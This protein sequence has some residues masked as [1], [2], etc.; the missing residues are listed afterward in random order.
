MRHR[1]SPS[2]GV[3]SSAA[4]V[5][6]TCAIAVSWHQ[7]PGRDGRYAEPCSA[8][9]IT[10]RSVTDYGVPN[11]QA[12]YDGIDY[13]RICGDF[14]R[15]LAPWAAPLARPDQHLQM[16]R[17][18]SVLARARVPRAAPIVRP[19]ELVEAASARGLLAQ[20]LLH[21]IHRT[22]RNTS[23]MM[24]LNARPLA[25]ASA[26]A[27]NVTPLNADLRE[28]RANIDRRAGRRAPSFHGVRDFAAKMRKRLVGH[29]KPAQ[30]T[31]AGAVGGSGHAER[32]T[33][34]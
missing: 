13:T 34:W 29:R 6:G 27:H 11:E 9:I 1:R 23:A 25:S 16:P 7:P 26:F 14:A 15:A 12:N 21:K 8:S 33:T 28:I 20:D 10:R 18:R 19:L 3:S 30:W 5:C 2:L 22:V 24:M 17:R 4:E 31:A 32:K